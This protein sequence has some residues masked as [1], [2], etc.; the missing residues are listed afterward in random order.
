MKYEKKEEI[1]PLTEREK[2]DLQKPFNLSD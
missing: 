2:I 1:K